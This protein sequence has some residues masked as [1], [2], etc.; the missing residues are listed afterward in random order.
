VS[1]PVRLYSW[2]NECEHRLRDALGL[3][4]ETFD[5]APATAPQFG[6]LNAKA[7]L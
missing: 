5:A 1:R 6:V 7:G 2:L 4:E 3:D